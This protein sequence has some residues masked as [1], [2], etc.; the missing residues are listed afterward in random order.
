MPGKEIRVR[1]NVPVD[2][3]G[4]AILSPPKYS[5]T[6]RPLANQFP[7]GF[8][9]WNTD[10]KAPQYSGGPNDNNWYDANGNLT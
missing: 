9:I 1:D 5:N 2:S 6:S 7:V 10:D 4:Y 3:E 8:E